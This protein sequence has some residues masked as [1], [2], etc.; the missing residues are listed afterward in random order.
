MKGNNGALQD[1]LLA[2][3]GVLMIALP[4]YWCELNPTELVF[5]ILLARLAAERARYNSSSNDEFHASIVD[6]MYEFSMDDCTLFFKKCG[7]K[8]FSNRII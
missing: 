6:E 4:P 3:L 5:Q 2:E 8:Y 7:Y 1:Q